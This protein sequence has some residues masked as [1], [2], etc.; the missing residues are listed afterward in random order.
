MTIGFCLPLNERWHTAIDGL[1]KEFGDGLKILRGVDES[2]AAF[3]ELDA[4]VANPVDE[5]FYADALRLKAVFIPF[6]GVNHLPADILM[7]KGIRAYN[8][9]GNA[10]SVAERALALALAGFGRVIEYHN[11][12]KQGIWHGFWVHKGR[13]D[14]WHS[15]FGSRCTILGAGAI[16]EALAKLLKAF[17]CRVV[18]YRRR[19]DAPLP[20]NFDEITQDLHAALSGARIVFVALPLTDAT[21][22]LIGREEFAA[23]KGGFLVNVGRGEVVQEEA[24]YEALKDGIISGAGLDVWYQYPQDGATTGWPSR[25]PLHELP[26]VVLSPHV[27][28]S[29]FEAVDRNIALSAENMALW[30]RSGEALHEVDLRQR[31]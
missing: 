30:L 12:L 20:P 10:Q 23:M 31:Y 29:T 9:H 17:D 1:Q 27:A 8:C 6:V 28:G 22:S 16:G 21:K 14:F 5:R 18:G 15:I 24:L 4:V 25:F 11:D 2:L 13:E 19:A 3:P 26:Q 7:R